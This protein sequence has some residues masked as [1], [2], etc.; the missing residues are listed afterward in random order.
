MIYVRD[1]YNYLNERYPFDTQ[2]PWDNSGLLCGDP[3]APVTSCVVSLDSDSK[4]IALAKE[5]NSSLL[6]TH[7][8]IIFSPLKS[9]PA[10]APAW[11]AAR[12]GLSVLCSH[13]PF[14]KGRDGTNDTLCGLLGLKITSNACDDILRITELPRDMTVREFA[15]LASK[16]LGA[17]VSFTLGEKRIRKPAVCTGAAGDEASAAKT[18]G[19]DCLLTGEAKYHEL[20]DAKE[21]G[22]PLICAGHFET[23]FPAMSALA[24]RLRVRFP[25]VTFYLSGPEPLASVIVR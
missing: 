21:A 3:E 20:L 17:D 9:L 5:T 19:A 2:E 12:L 4:A 23:E 14:D 13:T 16:T 22:F 11:N 24:Q 10:G 1:F 18:A 6:I 8:P 25:Q 7:H 15:E